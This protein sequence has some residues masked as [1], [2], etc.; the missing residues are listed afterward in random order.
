VAR[1]ATRGGTTR[2][3]A[4]P[5]RTG[6]ETTAAI[7]VLATTATT[8][9]P[10]NDVPRADSLRSTPSRVREG[11]SG[12]VVGLLAADVQQLARLPVESPK[13]Q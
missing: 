9:P 13:W 8:W 10:E 12:A 5:S 3:A 6:T 2:S 7:E 4:R 1:S 11:D